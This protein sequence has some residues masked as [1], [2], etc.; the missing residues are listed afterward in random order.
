MEKLEIDNSNVS[1]KTLLL[2]IERVSKLK[3]IEFLGL[4]KLLAVPMTV[5]EEKKPREFEEILSDCIDNFIM[6][7]RQRRKEVLS[8]LK[9]TTV[10]R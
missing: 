5:G 3:E 4:A 10:K 2:F 9:K 1:E 8:V 7:N 6:L